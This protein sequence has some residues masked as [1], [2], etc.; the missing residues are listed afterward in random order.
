MKPIRILDTLIL[1]Y[2]AGKN[3]QQFN[4]LFTGDAGLGKSDVCKLFVEIMRTKGFPEHGIDKNP[5][6]GFID[7]R[8]AYMEAPDFIGFPE[9]EKDKNGLSR[10]VHNIPEFWPTDPD[11]EGIILL[12][13]PNRGTTGVMN[14]MMQLLT[15]NKV[16][17]MELPKGWMK[18]GAINPDTAEYDVNAMDAA[19]KNRFVPYEIEFD[20]VSFSDYI[21]K[22]NWDSS[23]QSFINSG[24]WVYKGT[25]QLADGATYIS[26]RTWSQVNAAEKAG[27]RNDRILHSETV[28]AILGRDIGNEYHKFCYDEAPVT[29][30]DLIDDF[31]GAMKRLEKQSDPSTYKG[32][33]IAVTVE[34]ITQNYS[35]Q[36]KDKDGKVGEETMAAVAKVIPADQA[37]NLIKACGFKQSKGAITTFFKDFVKRNPELKE[38]LKASIRVGRGLEGS[39]E[40]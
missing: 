2:K 6:Y 17:K 9:S 25:A 8:A 3:G 15:D 29:A 10:T 30:K 16:H 40:G 32:D 26:P 33:M 11:S 18:A 12:E 37:I 14:C 31:K 19:L 4:P 39:S 28:R 7:L 34:S 27:L 20:F 36:L 21:A 35:C 38:V 1:A 24:A 5:N 22:K 23:V 13:E